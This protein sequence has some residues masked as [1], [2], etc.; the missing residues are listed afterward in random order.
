[1][2]AKAD[3]GLA[4][5][6]NIALF[7]SSTPMKVLDY[8]SSAIP[9]IMSNNENNASIFEDYTSAWFCDFNEENIK[10]KIEYIIALSK[11]EITN[12]GINGQKR[13]LAV[14]NYDRIAS[15]LAHQLNIL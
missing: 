4:V 13:L 2:I 14:R 10:A 5:L 6:P 15:D 12:V 11:E 7:N 1:M 3:I 9:C 8:Y